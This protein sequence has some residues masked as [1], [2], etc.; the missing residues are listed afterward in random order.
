MVD[1]AF[2]Q[3]DDAYP[4]KEAIREEV[5]RA[6]SVADRIHEENMDMENWDQEFYLEGGPTRKSVVKRRG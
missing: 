5:I 3:E 1:H 6:F 4:S 2:V